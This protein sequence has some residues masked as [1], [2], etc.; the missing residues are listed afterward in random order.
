MHRKLGGV[1][2]ICSIFSLITFNFLTNDEWDQCLQ[3]YRSGKMMTGDLKKLAIEHV[4]GFLESHRQLREEA[5]SRVD[6]FVLR[7]PMK[8]ILEMAQIPTSVS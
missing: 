8:S 6:E 2:E 3:D 5:K 1:P 4:S 7:T